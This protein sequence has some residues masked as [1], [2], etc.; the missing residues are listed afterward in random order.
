MNPK[1]KLFI[2]CVVNFCLIVTGLNAE[3]SIPL[4]NDS[5]RGGWRFFGYGLLDSGIDENNG[6]IVVDVDW[7]SSNWGIG[8]MYELRRPIDGRNIKE[9]RIKVKTTHGTETK[10]FGGFATHDDAN[11]SIDNNM[12]F[13]IIDQWQIISLPISQMRPTKPSKHSPNFSDEDWNK[14]QIVKILFLKPQSATNKLEKIYIKDP[15]IIVEGPVEYTQKMQEAPSVKLPDKIDSQTDFNEKSTSKPKRIIRESQTSKKI[16]SPLDKSI[17]SSP[18]KNI[19]A[20][21]R[22]NESP[23]KIKRNIR[24]LERVIEKNETASADYNK[25]LV[26]LL[27]DIS[28]EID[29]SRSAATQADRRSINRRIVSLDK[30]SDDLSQKITQLRKLLYESKQELISER[31]KIGMTGDHSSMMDNRFADSNH[32]NSSSDRSKRRLIMKKVN[33]PSRKKLK[34]ENEFDNLY[35]ETLTP[36]EILYNKTIQL[37]EKQRDIASPR[38]DISNLLLKGAGDCRDKGEH[39]YAL[40]LFK[41]AIAEDPKNAHAFRIYGDFLMGYRG[42]YEKAATQ[43]TRSSELLKELPDSYDDKFKKSLARS[44]KIHHRD[45]KDGIPVIE[46]KTFSIY[47]DAAVSYLEPSVNSEEPLAMFEQQLSANNQINRRNNEIINDPNPAVS[48]AIK[49]S[50]IAANERIRE[51]IPTQLA[52]RREE[53]QYESSVLLRFANEDL[54]YFRLSWATK[55]INTINVDPEDTRI[56]WDG[57]FIGKYALVGKNYIL[58]DDNDLKL[59]AEYSE[60]RLMTDSPSNHEVS[61]EIANVLDVTAQFIHYFD[62]NTLRLTLGSLSADIDRSESR[63]PVIDDAFNSQRVSLRLSFYKPPEETE[64]P[65]R[66]RGRRSDHIEIGFKRSEREFHRETFQYT[67]EPH[68][69]YEMLGLVN[70]HLDLLFKGKA[71][72]RRYTDTFKKGT[73]NA[74]EIGFTPTWF[75]IYD[76]YENDFESG[77]EYLTLGLPIQI[78]FDEQLSSYSRVNAGLKLEDQWVTDA[79]VRFE[80]TLSVDYAYYPHIHR[81]DWGVFAKCVLRY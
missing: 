25:K 50:R 9:I 76:L 17:Y 40:K 36:G 73:Y 62:I 8:G 32:A 31:R 16:V 19:K 78:T 61:R 24:R 64:N 18:D 75:F 79:G 4:L 58:S 47:W 54:P 63:D 21:I 60:R 56:R 67:Y 81:D 20:E 3:D 34:D 33:T 72:Q 23:G 49:N 44:I 10:F 41:D 45:G 51:K 80:P 70:G 48:A 74:Y 53:V 71:Y 29:K 37:V 77:H 27:N 1:I 13:E 38:R 35:Q 39:K 26:N 11:I 5:E 59:E 42:Q 68:I 30:K 57:N 46:A 28:F 7:N 66:F 2:Y 6:E 65:S 55:Y 69:S 12:A 22:D 14:I 43:Y 15:E 52:R